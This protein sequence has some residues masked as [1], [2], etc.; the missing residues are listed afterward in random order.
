MSAIVLPSWRQ[1]S[2]AL[3][4]SMLLTLEND[5]G[6]QRMT[7]VQSATIPLL[8]SHK[9]VAVEACTGSGKTL[10][11][12]IPL[13]EILLRRE[14]PLKSNEV[15]AII[16]TPIRELASQVC[17]IA[18]RIVRRLKTMTTQLLTGG[19]EDE[20]DLKALQCDGGHILIATPGRLQY[21][22]ENCMK[23]LQLKVKT[24]EVLILDEAD[25]LLDMGFE[26]SLNSILERLPKQ[27]RTGLFS[28]TLTPQVKALARA[29]LRNPVKVVVELESFPK[30]SVESMSSIRD[31]QKTPKEL[32][33]FYVICE[34]DEKTSQLV[35]F[36]LNHPNSKIII[37][38]LTCAC[39]D[40]FW[41]V[42]KKIDKLSSLRIFSLHGKIPQKNRTLTYRKF[43]NEKHCVL[44]STDI[45]SRGLDIPD[46][47]WIIQYD[48][49]QD[50]DVFVHRVG[51]TARMGREGNA[52]VYLLPCEDTYIE[53]LRV[54]KVPISELPA[55]KTCFDPLPIF[56]QWI[57]KERELFDKVIAVPFI[58]G[59]VSHCSLLLLTIVSPMLPLSLI[60]VLIRNTI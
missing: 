17:E 20:N 12:L 35:H 13:I 11:Y 55:E 53:F 41:K 10:A 14:E 22:L 45:A 37:Y 26:A 34:S 4:N 39:V 30:S 24:L 50:P 3:S 44:F 32:S 40:F 8:M 49:P 60:Y 59:R 27:R 51:R 58:D 42:F 54:R 18:Q 19:N 21:I 38:F 48:P 1:L 16:I 57:S 31:V 6:F 25:R 56:Q 15:G 23:Q 47:D 46:V 43:L 9:D 7:P 5:F 2:P 52:I 28:A 33:N 36:L 29:G